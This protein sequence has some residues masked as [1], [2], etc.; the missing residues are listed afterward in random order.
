MLS[1]CL[2]T[3]SSASELRR[4]FIESALLVGSRSVVSV[5]PV[6]LLSGLGPGQRVLLLGQG[7]PDLRAAPDGRQRVL[8]VAG[9]HGGGGGLQRVTVRDRLGRCGGGGGGGASISGAAG[10]GNPDGT[11]ELTIA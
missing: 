5:A 10:T 3:K 1:R 11:F 2:V 8:V 4:K 6:R 9:G 7:L